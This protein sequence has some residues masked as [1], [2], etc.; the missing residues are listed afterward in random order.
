MTRPPRPSS[1]LVARPESPRPIDRKLE[2]VLRSLIKARHVTHNIKAARDAAPP[3][4][5]N[6]KE[7]FFC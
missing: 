2:R 4:E 6:R 7:V 3:A 1:A 5:N